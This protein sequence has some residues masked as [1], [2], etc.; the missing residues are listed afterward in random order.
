[1]FSLKRKK[2]GPRCREPAF[3]VFGGVLKDLLSVQARALSL[4]AAFMFFNRLIAGQVLM[5]SIV[6]IKSLPA[7]QV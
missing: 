2:A 5:L 3:L 4:L 6:S 1:M 7:E